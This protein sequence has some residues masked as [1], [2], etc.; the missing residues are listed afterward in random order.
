MAP[1]RIC[2]AGSMPVWRH[3]A[4]MSLIRWRSSATARWVLSSLVAPGDRKSVV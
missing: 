3:R 2:S 4:R 1:L